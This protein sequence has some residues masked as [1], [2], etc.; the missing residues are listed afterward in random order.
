MSKLSP[1]FP[2]SLF[3][4]FLNV[5]ATLA[6]VS[7]ML[8]IKWHHKFKYSSKFNSHNNLRDRNNRTSNSYLDADKGRWQDGNQTPQNNESFYENK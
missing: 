6:E 7:V 5:R 4:N 8:N 2:N 3:P 1:I